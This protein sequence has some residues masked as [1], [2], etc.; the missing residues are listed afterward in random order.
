MASDTYFN[1]D[2]FEYLQDLV[3]GLSESLCE[4]SP[5]EFSYFLAHGSLDQDVELN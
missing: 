3:C 5:E 2:A 4:L 1:V